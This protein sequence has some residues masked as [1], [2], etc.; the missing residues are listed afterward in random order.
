MIVT[1]V[2]VSNNSIGTIVQKIISRLGEF[3]N[4][5]FL[6]VK[7]VVDM[8]SLFS[9]SNFN[10]DI[11]EWVTG[12]VRDMEWMFY[13]SV[14]DKDISKWDVSLVENMRAMFFCAIFNQDIST[15]HTNTVHNVSYMFFGSKFNQK[16]SNW[17]VENVIVNNT[18]G[19]ISVFEGSP[20]ENKP[21]FQPKFKV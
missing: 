17:N 10:G 13:K 18:N 7:N 20:L 19:S 15:W 12:S 3:C 9:S 6:D 8:S 16:I 14:F 21:E 5:N 11:S 1:V 4:M 2:N